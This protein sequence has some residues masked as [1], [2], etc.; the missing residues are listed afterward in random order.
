MLGS[1]PC[2]IL[3]GHT[4]NI[5]LAYTLKSPGLET[6]GVPQPE[7]I[8]TVYAPSSPITIVGIV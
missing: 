1:V 6:T 8:V 2:T 3:V 5:G 4:V 7:L